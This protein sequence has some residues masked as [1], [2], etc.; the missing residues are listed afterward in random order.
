MALS[1]EN[2]APAQAQ[3]VAGWR[4]LCVGIKTRLTRQIES[5]SLCRRRF[6]QGREAP[7]GEP[8][9]ATRQGVGCDLA[10]TPQPRA[11]A[12]IEKIILLNPR[13]AFARICWFGL[14]TWSALKNRPI[15]PIENHLAAVG[16]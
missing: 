6:G 12:V 8:P 11:V 4:C 15:L 9:I 5:K 1:P 16:T 14:F 13:Y 3:R 2:F 10:P 7:F